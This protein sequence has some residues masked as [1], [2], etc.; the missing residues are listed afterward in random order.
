MSVKMGEYL[1]EGRFAS[2]DD[3]KERAGVFAVLCRMEDT[4]YL[5]DVGEAG[6]VKSAVSEHERRECWKEYC[7]GELFYVV[8]YTP[9]MRE[10]ARAE[11]EQEI[12]GQYKVPCGG[13]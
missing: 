4:N 12:R 11:I 8:H 9:G 1:F 2:T 10:N 3:L 5:I 7:K 6:K 13:D